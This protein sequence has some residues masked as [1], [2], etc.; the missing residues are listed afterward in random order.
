[1]IEDYSGF[2]K[3][4]G[5]SRGRLTASQKKPHKTQSGL[6]VSFVPV[7]WG[8]P[9]CR[10]WCLRPFD[11]V[12]ANPSISREGIDR[13]ATGTVKW[14][15]ESKGYGLVTPDG[16]GD[17]VFAHFSAI[18]LP[19][20][21]PLE[22]WETPQNPGR[23]PGFFCLTQFSPAGPRL[24]EIATVLPYKP[25]SIQPCCRTLALAARQTLQRIEFSRL[26]AALFLD[27]VAR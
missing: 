1:M 8:I 4:E 19:T 3:W 7:F 14:F 16:G 17:D 5:G 23:C 25:Y 11:L 10:T 12:R 13:M 22:V 18:Q 27:D 15:N 21:R 20:S 6:K 9:G 26:I 24:C 2:F